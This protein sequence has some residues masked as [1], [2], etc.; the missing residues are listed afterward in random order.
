[1]NTTQKLIFISPKTQEQPL[2]LLLSIH[3]Q[4]RDL[5]RWG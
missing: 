3:L 4:S 2:L 5:W 1:M